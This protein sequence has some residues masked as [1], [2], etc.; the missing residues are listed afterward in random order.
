MKIFTIL[1]CIFTLFQ[2]SKDG[3]D[4]KWGITQGENGKDGESVE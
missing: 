2:L 1:I 4:G 3:D